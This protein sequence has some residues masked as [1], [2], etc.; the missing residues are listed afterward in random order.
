VDHVFL[1]DNNSNNSEAMLAA[2]T[3]SFPSTFLT[4]RVERMPKAQLKTYAWCAE[5]QRM[6]YNWIAFFDMDEYLVVREGNRRHPDLKGLLDQYKDEPG[7][8]VNWIAVGPSGRTN[9]PP[10]GGVMPYY[11]QCVPDPDRHIKTI[12]NTW[13]L[14]GVA[15]HPHNFH[16]RCACG[17]YLWRP[18]QASPYPLPAPQLCA[19]RNSAA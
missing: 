18:L 17:A 10:R 16:F 3:D 4:V 11:T 12:A 8:S 14:D 5:Q 15:L 13:F 1:T 9:R 7:L 19:A 2:L 6:N